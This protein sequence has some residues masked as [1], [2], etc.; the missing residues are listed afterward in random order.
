M[1]AETW[2]PQAYGGFPFLSSGLAAR[3]SMSDNDQLNDCVTTGRL[4]WWQVDGQRA[5]LIGISRTLDHGFDGYLMIEQVVDSA[6]VGRGSAAVAQGKLIT[7]LAADNPDLA[8]FGT[9]DARNIPSLRTA[10]ANGRVI[11]GTKWFLTPT[12]AC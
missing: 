7:S 4:C 3:V 9:I 5:G 6:F 8:F 2:L 11:H 12:Q 1:E 10:A